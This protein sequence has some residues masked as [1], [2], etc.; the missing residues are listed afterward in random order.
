MI[1]II[2]TIAFYFWMFTLSGAAVCSI[3]QLL[4]VRRAEGAT[5]RDIF[6]MY[7]ADDRWWRRA[8]NIGLAVY[9]VALILELATR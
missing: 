6:E 4:A 1:S 7:E 3:R 8:Q 9:A 5:V 2:Y